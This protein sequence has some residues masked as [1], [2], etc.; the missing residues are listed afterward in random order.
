MGAIKNATASQKKKNHAVAA[1][2]RLRGDK[3]EVSIALRYAR[4]NLIL[5]I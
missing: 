3:C 1:L 4:V 2:N 5:T